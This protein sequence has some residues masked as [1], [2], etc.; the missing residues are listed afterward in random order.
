[1]A[2][3]KKLLKDGRP[4]FFV[5]ENQQNQ[6]RAAGILLYTKVDGEIYFLFT[7]Y[8]GRVWEDVGGKTDIVDKDAIDTATRECGEETNCAFVSS[9]KVETKEQ[10]VKL[11]PQS[12]KFFKGLIKKQQVKPIYV[13]HSKYII[14][15]VKIK[16]KSFLRVTAEMLSDKEHWLGY[17][18]EAKWISG[19]ELLNLYENGEVHV[20]LRDPPVYQRLKALVEGKQ[21]AENRQI[22]T[23]DNRE[24]NPADYNNWRSRINVQCV[25]S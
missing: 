12:N 5:D 14:Y 25:T 16:K 1:M 9:T 17:D 20:R 22:I 8:G 19:Q 3:N 10:V 13:K 24:N 23:D 15:P 21:V 11:L 2:N 4:T 6:I 18:R 7:R